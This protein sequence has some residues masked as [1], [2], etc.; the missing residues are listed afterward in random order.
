MILFKTHI[1]KLFLY[2]TFMT[3]RFVKIVGIYG[4]WTFLRH[5]GKVILALAQ[6]ALLW[7]HLGCGGVVQQCHSSFCHNRWILMFDFFIIVFLPKGAEQACVSCIYFLFLL[8]SC[9]YNGFLAI[10]ARFQW[11][12]IPTC[13]GLKASARATLRATV[14]CCPTFKTNIRGFDL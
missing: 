10:Q 5:W 8:L 11:L 3:F 14:I 4:H 2:I 12:A 9:I 6:R 13:F 7:S 1:R